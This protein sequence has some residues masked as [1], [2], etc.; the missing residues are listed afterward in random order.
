MPTRKLIFRQA[1][2]SGAGVHQRCR[3]G[4]RQ[5]LQQRLEA[6]VDDYFDEQFEEFDQAGIT[7]SKDSRLI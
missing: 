7:D 2:R 5:Q 1:V 6:D 3:T 4:E